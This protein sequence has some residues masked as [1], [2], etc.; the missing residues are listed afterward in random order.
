[1]QKKIIETPFQ[2]ETYFQKLLEN[3][4]DLEIPS[5]V[6]EKYITQIK[7]IE[8]KNIWML[9]DGEKRNVS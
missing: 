3:C 5:Y 7:N 1:M 2:L 4:K 6:I 8:K 9:K